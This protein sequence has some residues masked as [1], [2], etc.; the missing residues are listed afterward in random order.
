M[1]TAPL[2]NRKRVRTREIGAMTVAFL[3]TFVCVPSPQAAQQDVGSEYT[4]KANFLA[5]SA[6]FFEWQSD[7]PLQIANSFRWC[8]YGNFSFGT[9]LAEMTRDIAVEGK[10]SEVK[11]IH[12]E[13]ELASCQIIF[14]SRSEEKHY[15]KILDAARP[16]RGLT[17]GETPSF[18]DAGGMVTLL[19]DGKTPQFEVN[20]EP[21]SASRLKLSSRMLSL[22]RR[23]VNHATAAKG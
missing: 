16:G 6:S 7:S 1:S 18:L 14:V 3:L 23:V 5:R 10:R 12:K 4:W 15:A 20:L 17:V 19:T 13:T 22:A 2:R 21:A 9:T 11:W 8:V